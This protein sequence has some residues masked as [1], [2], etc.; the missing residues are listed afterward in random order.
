M[1]FFVC[2]ILTIWYKPMYKYVN[3]FS[4]ILCCEFQKKKAW[5][6]KGKGRK[7]KSC[8]KFTVGF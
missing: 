2:G 4:E 3:I 6:Y 1:K 7:V 8:R 5:K